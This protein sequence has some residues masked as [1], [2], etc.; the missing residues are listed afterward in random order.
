MIGYRMIADAFSSGAY[1]TTSR[2]HRRADR[3]CPS[4]ALHQRSAHSAVEEQR[5]TLRFRDATWPRRSNR[6]A[7]PRRQCRFADDFSARQTQRRGFDDFQRSNRIVEAP[8][9]WSRSTGAEITS[10]NDGKCAINAFASAPVS[11]RGLPRAATVQRLVIR[12]VR[13]GRCKP[14][15]QPLAVAEIIRKV[16]DP[17]FA[18]SGCGG[19]MGSL[20]GERGFTASL[21]SAAVCSNCWWN[22]D[23]S[24]ATAGELMNTAARAS[25]WATR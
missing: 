8:N 1:L 20:T 19:A 6:A 9:S 18:N 23:F 12:K 24:A 14:I 3:R 2:G 11:V 4:G 7:P 17:R 16:G 22:L 15:A 25:P 21:R 10:A 13:A 5:G